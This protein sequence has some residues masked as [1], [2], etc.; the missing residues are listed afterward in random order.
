MRQ[1]YGYG[2]VFTYRQYNRIEK[3]KEERYYDLWAVIVFVC[4]AM[5][6]ASIFIFILSKTKIYFLIKKFNMIVII[7]SLHLKINIMLADIGK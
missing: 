3:I 7:F 6:A 5:P 4:Q 1:I 2:F